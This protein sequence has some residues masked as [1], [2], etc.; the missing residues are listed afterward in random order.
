MTPDEINQEQ[1]DRLPQGYSLFCWLYN[2][3]ASELGW[4]V[5]DLATGNRI[6]KSQN[7]AKKAVDMALAIINN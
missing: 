6:V 7:T 2:C 5:K 1:A 3:R 4:G